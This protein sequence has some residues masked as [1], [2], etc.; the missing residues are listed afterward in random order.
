MAFQPSI[1]RRSALSLTAWLCGFTL[2]ELLVVIAIISM[3]AAL[4]LPALARAQEKTKRIRCMN[5]LRQLGLS[6]KMYADDNHGHL[7]AATWWKVPDTPDSD[8]DSMD[9]DMTW[10]YPHYIKSIETFLCPSA[11]HFISLSNRVSKPDGTEVPRDLVFIATKKRTEGMSYEV[12]GNF[13]G[14]L[15]PKKTEGTILARTLRRQAPEAEHR[16]VGPAEIFLMVDGDDSTNPQDQNNYPD[17]RDDNHGSEGGNMY[18]CD[19]HARW[20]PQRQWRAVWNLSQDN[21]VV[22]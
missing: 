18:F 5:N 15:G 16:K 14:S 12:L 3:L 13:S 9:D 6:S 17:W 1:L 11:G 10:I 21:P 19:G 2:V 8:R 20:V 7:T 22:P 4:L